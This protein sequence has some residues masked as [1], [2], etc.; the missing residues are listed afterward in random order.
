MCLQ[1]AFIRIVFPSQM[2]S[3]SIVFVSAWTHVWTSTA[4]HIGDQSRSVSWH[5]EF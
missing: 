2:G 4:V 5:S 1:L 3:I